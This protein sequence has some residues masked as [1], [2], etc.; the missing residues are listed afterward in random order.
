MK[1]DNDDMAA[2][3][4]PIEDMPAD[5]W[6]DVRDLFMYGEQFVNF[7]VTTATDANKATLPVAS[8]YA[9]VALNKSYMPDADVA[10]LFVD[11][12]NAPY[13]RCDGRVDLSIL[14]RLEDTS[15]ASP[16]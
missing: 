14:T 10:A 13:V 3:R 9:P 6:L 4:G 16:A 8:A 5:Y 15:P 7:E 11:P 2:L 1:F 12:V